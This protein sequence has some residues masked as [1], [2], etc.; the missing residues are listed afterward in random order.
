[1]MDEALLDSE[2]SYGLGP[3]S[4][5]GLYDDTYMYDDPLYDPL[6]Y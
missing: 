4:A 5:A 1:M 3:Y 2:L 6:V